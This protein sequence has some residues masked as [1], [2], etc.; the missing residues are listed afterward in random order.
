MLT[1]MNLGHNRMALWC[2]KECIRL[3]GEEDILDVGC[4]G[5]QNIANFL[6]RT[7]GKVYGVDY[8][9][10][11]VAQ[12]VAKNRKAVREGRT[13]VIKTTVSSLPYDAETFDLITAFETV[14][15]WPDIVE[16]FK[17]VKR[18][19]KPGGRFV[20]CNECSSEEG[21]ERWVSLLDMKIYTPEMLVENMTKAGF[22]QIS[23]FQKGRQIC[24][25]GLK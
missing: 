20:V 6:K 5:G 14:Y 8:S 7:K 25:I 4:G 18:V 3:N 1:Q 2:I 22:T 9:A 16:D 15:F 19:L 12:S 21:N 10:Q 11:S 24:V 13:E 17:E 23:V